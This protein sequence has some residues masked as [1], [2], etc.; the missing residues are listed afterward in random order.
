M[1]HFY[2]SKIDPA[3]LTDREIKQLKD[4]EVDQELHMKI[5]GMKTDGL[6]INCFSKEKGTIDKDFM[7]FVKEGETYLPEKD[8]TDAQKSGEGAE[9]K[10]RFLNILA[11]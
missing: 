3:K 2:L 7:V 4:R 5:Q 6:I 1:S 9:M 11:L 10:G 8:L